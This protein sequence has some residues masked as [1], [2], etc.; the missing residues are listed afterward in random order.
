MTTQSPTRPESRVEPTY[1]SATE[2]FPLLAEQRRRLVLHY[3]SRRV[4]SVRL[5]DLAEQVARWEGSPTDDNVE[6]VRTNLYHNHLPRLVDWGLIRVDPE[7]GTV[8]GLASLRWVKPYLTL[9]LADD[10][11]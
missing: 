3:L 2:I 8:V 1:L 5:A 7:R 11:R 10:V 9:A 4:G 6:R